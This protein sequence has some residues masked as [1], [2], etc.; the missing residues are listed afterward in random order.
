MTISAPPAPLPRYHFL[1]WVR[2]L[3]FF[4][5]IVYHV[6]MY[7]VTWGWHVKSPYASDALEPYMMLSAPWR[8]SLLF[9]VSGVASS[10]MLAK[11]RPGAFLR[12][13][14][15]RLLV[16]LLFGMLVIV[17]PQS[18]FEVVEKLGYAGSYADFMRLYLRGYH[19]FC[20]D[21]CLILPTWNHLWFVVYLWAYT[22]V[23]ALLTLAL[24]A[25]FDRLAAGLG[26]LLAGWKIVVLPAAV[27]ALVRILMLQRFP[28]THA[29]V[30]D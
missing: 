18:Y 1:D 26:R 2:I 30:D 27:L 20:K 4:L 25:R 19:G 6:G 29:L 3:A 9:L 14:S 15:W 13:R 17:P 16:P 7:Y 21:G 10:C 8:L 28:I 5:L 22:A 12:T 23:L 24:G 11:L